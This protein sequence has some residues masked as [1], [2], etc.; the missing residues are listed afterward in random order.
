LFRVSAV[1]LQESDLAHFASD[2]YH[3]V[4]LSLV[5]LARMLH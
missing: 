3:R 1:L 5:Q 2:H 4:A